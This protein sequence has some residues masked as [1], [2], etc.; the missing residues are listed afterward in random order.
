MLLLGL[1]QA[2]H[3]QIF[4]DITSLTSGGTGVG[5]FSGTLGAATVTGSIL[6]SNY[7][8]SFTFNPTSSGTLGAWELSN[9]G[10]TSPQ[11]S[12]STIYATAKNNVDTLGYTLFNNNPVGTNNTAR[13]KINFSIPIKDLVINVANLDNSIWD[14]TASGGVTSLTLLKGNG[15]GGDGLGISGK[16]I[17]DLATGDAGIAPSTTPTTSGTRSGYGSV[18]I[19]GTYSSLTIDL[20]ATHSLGGDGGN[21]TFT[22]VPEPTSL[23]LLLPGAAG[24]LLLR[25]RRKN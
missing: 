5:A 2:S 20:T 11:F 7:A 8:N 16:T 21:F 13:M 22:L 15:G 14:F 18:M 19:N 25:R 1:G 23:G 4:M 6:S 9:T 10:G 17:I 3:A 24:L 12:Y